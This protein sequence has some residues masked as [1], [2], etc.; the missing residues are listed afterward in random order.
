MVCTCASCCNIGLQAFAPVRIVVLSTCNSSRWC[1]LFQNMLACNSITSSHIYLPQTQLS[2]LVS[3]LITWFH[4]GGLLLAHR[5][6]PC[7][8][9]TRYAPRWRARRDGRVS[10]SKDGPPSCTTTSPCSLASCCIRRCR[11]RQSPCPYLAVRRIRSSGLG[12]GNGG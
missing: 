12:Q 2:R 5:P 4:G 7:A 11:C 8:I 3:L 10:G 9:A 1:R 6:T